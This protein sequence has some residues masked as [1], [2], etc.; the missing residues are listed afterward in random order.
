MKVICV[1][2]FETNICQ[3]SERIVPVPQV[4]DIDRVAKVRVFK[5]RPTYILEGYPK[6]AGYETDHF[7]KLSNID[8]LE[9]VNERESQLASL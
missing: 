8:E 7:A 5:K 9:L 2:K 1:K 4:G 6:D 3:N